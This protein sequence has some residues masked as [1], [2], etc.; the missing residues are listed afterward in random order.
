MVPPFPCGS[1]FFQGERCHA[2][3]SLDR[4]CHPRAAALSLEVDTAYF[5]KVCTS[6]GLMT[7]VTTASPQSVVA[8][9]S[10][11]DHRTIPDSNLFTDSYNNIY[12]QVPYFFT[13]LLRLYD[14][15]SCH[16]CRCLVYSHHLSPPPT[17]YRIMTAHI[18]VR[19]DLLS[20]TRPR[21]VG[22]PKNA[23]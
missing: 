21:S 23:A 15:T 14:A 18:T 12:L 13:Y 20:F 5:P 10:D 19:F 1:P 3:T 8:T 22:L 11:I 4:L 6:C 7:T 17:A 9:L 2:A 16:V